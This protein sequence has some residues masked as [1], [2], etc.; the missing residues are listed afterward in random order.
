MK[1]PFLAK[2]GGKEGLIVKQKATPLSKI[3]VNEEVGRRFPGGGRSKVVVQPQHIVS[4]SSKTGAQGECSID[5]LGLPSDTLGHYNCI[6][7]CTGAKMRVT[8]GRSYTPSILIG[9]LISQ[10]DLFK[11]KGSLGK[12]IL[13]NVTDEAAQG[14]RDSVY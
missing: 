7:K 6:V 10:P 3:Y 13:Q 9:G 1:V 4:S 14:R 8:G 5:V 12:P 11:I 2:T